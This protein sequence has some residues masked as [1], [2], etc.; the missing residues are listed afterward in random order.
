MNVSYSC[1]PPRA[2]IS[3]A[4]ALSVPSTPAPIALPEFSTVPT[5]ASLPEFSSAPAQSALSE[6]STASAPTE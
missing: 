6:L 1:E 3:S 5:P 2:L 4:P